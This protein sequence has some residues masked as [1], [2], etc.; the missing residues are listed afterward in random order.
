MRAHVW[1]HKNMWTIEHRWKTAAAVAAAALELCLWFML[2]Q[3]NALHPFSS[4][5]R[6]GIA[7][8]GTHC[9]RV[10][11]DEIKRNTCIDGCMNGRVY[12][13]TTLY[14]PC[15]VDCDCEALCLRLCVLILVW[16]CLYSSVRLC[17]CVSIHWDRAKEKKMKKEKKNNK[18]SAVNRISIHRSS[19]THTVSN[20]GWRKRTANVWPFAVCE[21]T[22]KH[23]KKNRFAL[24][25][26]AHTTLAHTA[27]EREGAR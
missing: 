16:V 25:R 23:N 21:E 10:R 4:I 9:V 8:N 26:E 7:V 19:H 22:H 6:F 20:D 11:D 24:P 27:R 13:L 2:S 18:K 3:A 1:A 14:K 17:V 15:R 12:R 5:F